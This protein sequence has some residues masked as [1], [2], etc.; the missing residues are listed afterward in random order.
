MSVVPLS[1]LSTKKCYI[2]ILISLSIFKENLSKIYVFIS[3]LVM[4]REVDRDWTEWTENE[5]YVTKVL[6]NK[7]FF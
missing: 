3:I 7:C 2:A 5:K 4:D 1:T 6:M